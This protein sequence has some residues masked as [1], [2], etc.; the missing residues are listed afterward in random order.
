VVDVLLVADTHLDATRATLL[1]E[2][3]GGDL[4]TADVVLHAGDITHPSVLSDLAAHAPVHAVKGNNDGA[5]DLPDRL[6][7]TVEGC[8]FAMVHDSG[9]AAGRTRRLRRWFPHADVVVFGHS[10][11]PWYETDVAMNG[12]VQHHVNPGSPIVRRQAPTCSVAHV[13]VEHG[14]IVEVR[15]MPVAQAATSAPRQRARR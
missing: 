6:T 1:T 7:I 8:V 10:H 2:R 3:I 15:H 14:Q 5:L 9:P 13:I 4:M 12:H 11:L